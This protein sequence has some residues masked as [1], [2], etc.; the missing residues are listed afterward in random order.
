MSPKI[1]KYYS[2]T[3]LEFDMIVY[4]QI[5]KDGG[6]IIAVENP[7]GSKRFTHSDLIIHD[8]L[9]TFLQPFITW[10]KTGI[11]LDMPEPKLI[12]EAEAVACFLRCL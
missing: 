1:G 10:R 4:F 7:V 9:R 8:R 6:T 3:L 5:Q 12:D 2:W 11:V